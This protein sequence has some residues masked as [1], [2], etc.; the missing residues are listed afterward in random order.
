MSTIFKNLPKDIRYII[1]DY[2]KMNNEYN[3]VINELKK[4]FI[5]IKV[6]SEW[7]VLE[8]RKLRQIKFY[9]SGILIKHVL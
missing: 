3:D 9:P 8:W 6:Y 1:I 4:R 5:I 7:D 2:C